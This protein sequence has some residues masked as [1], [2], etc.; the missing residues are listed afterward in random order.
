VRVAASN[1]VPTLVAVSGELRPDR[2]NRRELIQRGAGAALGLGVSTA[3][4]RVAAARAAVDPRLAALAR[5]LD[6]DL[7]VPSDATY[8]Q[9]RALWNPRFDGIRP[10]AIAYVATVA[11]VRRAIKWA[12]GYRVDFA[13]RSGGHSFGGFST[14]TGL[15]LD[16]SRLSNIDLRPDGSA[17]VGAG[18]RLGQV[19]EA[20]WTGGRAV[21]LGSCPTV[22]VSGL[23]LGG[24]HGFSSRA[25]GLACDNVVGTEILTA[26]G[27]VRLCDDRNHPDLFW[28]LRGGGVESYGVVTKLLFRTHPVGIVTTVNLEWP[29][30]EATKAILAWQGFAPS[31]PDALSCVLPLSPPATAGAPPRISLNG[32]VF[33]TRDEALAILRPLTDVVP[34]M[35]VTAVQRP[36]I[37]AVHYFAGGNPP[38]RS[39]A[40]KSNYGLKPLPAAALD[41]I[42]GA[43]EAAARDRRL[44]STEV[45]LFAHG[46]AINRV[47]RDATAFVHRNALFSIRYTAFWDAPAGTTAANRAWL[48]S[49]HAA[50]QPYVTGAVTNYADP[51]LVDWRTAYYGSHLKRLVAVKRRYDPGNLFRFAQSIP[52]RL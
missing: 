36:F 47:G 50:M 17:Q 27:R 46:G 42:V 29:W 49:T 6:G 37:V 30:S 8:G 34:P 33:G 38:R 43:V 22:G 14:T 7:V 1:Q 45:A 52:T 40:A 28:A 2:Y 3:G 31:A 12:K 21:P 18:A 15:V 41:V 9:A 48:R 5:V 32:Q 24:G 35:K 25:L 19:Y 10:L 44:A 11:D 4:W 16:L 26:D 51:D 20:L 13:V 23:T 39:Y